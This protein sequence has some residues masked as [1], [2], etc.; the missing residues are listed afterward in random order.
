M[1]AMKAD[2]TG[3]VGKQFLLCVYVC[4][5]ANVDA[6]LRMRGSLETIFQVA[7]LVSN[8]KIFMNVST[9]SFK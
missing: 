4:V 5:F 7:Y 1:D 3:A 9:G 8:P 6:F 2:V